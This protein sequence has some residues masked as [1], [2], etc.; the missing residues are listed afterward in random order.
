MS[1]TLGNKDA[2]GSVSTTLQTL[3]LEHGF[4]DREASGEPGGLHFHL[5]SPRETIEWDRFAR[6]QG[7]T[8][9]NKYRSHASLTRK[10]NLARAATSTPGMR[11]PQTFVI[12]PMLLHA[13]D[14]GLSAIQLDKRKAMRAK[15]AAAREEFSEIGAREPGGGCWIIKDAQGAKGDNIAVV[16]GIAAALAEVDGGA[17]QTACVVQRYVRAP[18]LLPGGRKFDVRCWVLFAPSMRVYMHR[19]GVCR[20][21][22]SE[23]SDDLSDTLAH[24]TNHCVQEKHPDFG[25]HEEGN[26]LFFDAFGRWLHTAH[27]VDFEAAVL[28]QLHAIIAHSAHAV[29]EQ[30]RTPPDTTVGSFQLLGYDFLL[31]ATYAPHL[32]EVNGSPAIAA[33]LNRT[34]TA[35]MLA[36]LLAEHTPRAAAPPAAGATAAAP[37]AA[38]PPLSPLETAQCASGA[39]VTAQA[40]RGAACAERPPNNGFQLVYTPGVPPA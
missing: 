39:D 18:L 28:P 3:L 8:L 24:I 25:S 12:T 35:D 15:D 10:S 33:V 30:L 9:V 26:E 1:R 7:K 38:R 17:H 32:L 16:E 34:I 29:Y 27:G 11:H 31:D 40:D 20:T 2:D 4:E 21:S 14:E 6:S 5:A 19:Q 36:L 23:Y 37:P 22:S 13:A